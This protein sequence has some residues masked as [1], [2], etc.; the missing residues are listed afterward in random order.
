MYISPPPSIKIGPWS[1][2]N[3]ERGAN[4][5][6]THT[7]TPPKKQATPTPPPHTLSVSLSLTLSLYPCIYTP[8][9]YTIKIG[10]WSQLNVERGANLLIPVPD[11]LGGVVIVGSQTLTY[12]RYSYF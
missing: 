5:T 11:P 3:V 2:P 4:H 9:T 1:Q 6:P 10:P 7:Q 8:F 12:H